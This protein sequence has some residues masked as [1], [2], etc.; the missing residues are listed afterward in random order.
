MQLLQRLRQ[1]LPQH[2]YAINTQMLGDSATLAWSNLGLWS[3]PAQTYVQACEQ[4]AEH[5]AQCIQLTAQDRLLDL[6]CGHG[7]SLQYWAQ[8]YAVQHIEAVEIQTACIEKIQQQALACVRA[9]HQR[10]FMNLNAECFEQKFDAMVCLDALYHYDLKKFIAQISPLL[11]PKGRIGFHY[12]L[13]NDNWSKASFLS[14][15]RDQYLLKLADVQLQHLMYQTE[16][17]QVLTRHGFEQIQ[18]Q[19]LSEPVLGGFAEYV[20]QKLQLHGFQHDLNAL[21]IQMTAKLC[22]QLFQEQ[23]IDYV[24]VTATLA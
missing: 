18:I 2:K 4:L 5:L 6:G 15:Q 23:R 17:E 14:K 12:L 13:F 11:Q 20:Q 3:A 24:Q 7:A 19:I 1:K 22:Q 9:V 10:S 8:H 21:K 16:L